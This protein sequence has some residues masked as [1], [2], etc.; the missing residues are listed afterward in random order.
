[1]VSNVIILGIDGSSDLIRWPIDEN[2]G[3]SSA[4]RG[5]IEE[6]RWPTDENLGS[7][8]EDGG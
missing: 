2:R 8:R 6:S 5:P 7:C 4:S 1:M 3:S